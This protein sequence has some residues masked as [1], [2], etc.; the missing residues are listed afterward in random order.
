MPQVRPQKDKKKKALPES[1]LF[2]DAQPKAEELI[3]TIKPCELLMTF[4]PWTWKIG[5]Q[6][7]TYQMIN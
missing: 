5:H 4:K 2:T 1:L 6:V 3:D 7:E